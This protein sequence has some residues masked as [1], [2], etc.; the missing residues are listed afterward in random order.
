MACSIAGWHL[1]RM[2]DFRQRFRRSDATH[3]PMRGRRPPTRESRGP[4]AAA[5][6]SAGEPVRTRDG[7][8]LILRDI[9]RDDVEALR[10]GFS[11][12]TPEEVRLRFLHPLTELPPD[13]ALQFCDIDAA[14]A[15]ALVL[16]DPDAPSGAEIHAVARAYV[17]PAT[18]AAEFA[19]VVQH[20]FAGQGLGTLLMQRL[21][22]RCRA[23]G[24]VEIWGDVLAENGAM[25]ELCA[26]LGFQ[27][28][29]LFGD[30]GIQRVTLAL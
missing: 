21:F 17:D 25:L 8:I 19:L 12:L 14:H 9:H 22:D 2:N 5:A 6:A 28:H 30:P 11:H 16:I 4:P 1:V 7:R 20:S 10:R 24:A 13:M 18:L 29:S 15:V 26:N 27:Q 3:F 23:L